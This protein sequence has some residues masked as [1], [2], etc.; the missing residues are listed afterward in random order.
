VPATR[1]QISRY[2]PTPPTYGMKTAGLP[3]TFAPVC[4]EAALSRRV[5]AA[6]SFTWDIH[7]HPHPVHVH[8]P[9]L[10][11]EGTIQGRRR[12]ECFRRPLP[13]STTAVTD[14]VDSGRPERSSSIN[15]HRS[16]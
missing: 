11:L 14:N 7:Q 2:A 3:G 6:T 5:R 9:R 15:G 12:L 1:V 4:Q 10:H 8:S 13:S 16:A